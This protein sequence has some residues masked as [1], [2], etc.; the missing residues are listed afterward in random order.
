MYRFTLTD[1]LTVDPKGNVAILPSLVALSSVD[2]RER[3]EPAT[4]VVLV[5]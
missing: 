2:S 5:D 1:P 3:P 4:K